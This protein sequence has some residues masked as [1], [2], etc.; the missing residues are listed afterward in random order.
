MKKKKRCIRRWSIIHVTG[1]MGKDFNQ[2]M[3]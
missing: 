2:D 1:C 3:F